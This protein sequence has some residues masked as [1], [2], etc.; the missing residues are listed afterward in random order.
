MGTNAA[1]CQHRTVLDGAGMALWARMASG[2]LRRRP[3]LT[4]AHDI[5]LYELL[6][7]RNTLHGE[8]ARRLLGVA[9]VATNRQK[10]MARRQSGRDR[11]Y[12]SSADYY[13]ARNGTLLGILISS[14]R[15]ESDDP[16]HDPAPRDAIA[17]DAYV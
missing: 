7:I 9:A 13:H 15:V 14:K 5:R 6:F 17:H 16:S 12:H 3:H 8:F 10:R 2:L 1:E 11:F 4:L